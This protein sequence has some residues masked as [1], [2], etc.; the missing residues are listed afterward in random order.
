MDMVNHKSDS[1]CCEAAHENACTALPE[2]C[3]ECCL[4][5][6]PT[7]TRLRIRKLRGCGA[8]TSR[9][10]ALGFTPGTTLIV[11]GSGGAQ[12][13]RVQVRDTCMVLDACASGVIVC[14]P[15]S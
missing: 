10:Y 4:G 12:G 8:I 11:C 9:L 6:Y 13:C 7:G 15:V 2:E 14:D 1:C 5:N 3:E